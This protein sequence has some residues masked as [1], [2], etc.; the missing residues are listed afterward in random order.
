MAL[1]IIAGYCYA[2]CRLLTVTYAECHI[3]APCTE[4]RYAKCHYTECHGAR[5][6]PL[7]KSLKEVGHEDKKNNCFQFIKLCTV[8][9]I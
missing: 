8:S 6:D 2:E 3:K 1:S 5:I 7:H 4:C 9:K